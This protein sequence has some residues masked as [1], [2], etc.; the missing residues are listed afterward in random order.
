MI[1]VYLWLFLPFF[2][3][4]TAELKSCDEEFEESKQ[5]I[6]TTKDFSS[7]FP[8]G[9]SATILET[10]LRLVDVHQINVDEKSISLYIELFTFWNDTGISMSKGAG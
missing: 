1:L 10:E 5:S 3:V 4:S 9:K 2:K 7:L 6:C 8:P